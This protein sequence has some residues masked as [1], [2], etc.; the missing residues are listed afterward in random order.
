[1]EELDQLKEK[2]QYTIN[3][4]STFDEYLAELKSGYLDWTPLHKSSLFWKNNISKFDEDHHFYLKLLIDLVDSSNVSKTIIVAIN[5]LQNYLNYKAN[6]KRFFNN[7][8]FRILEELG[9]KEILVKLLDNSNEEIR[10]QSLLCMQKLLCS[11]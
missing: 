1:M 6:S 8:Y 10:Y 2:L 11:W 5:D 7:I 4:F 9:L 3:N